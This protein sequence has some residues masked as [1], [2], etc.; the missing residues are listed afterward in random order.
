MTRRTLG[1]LENVDG[2]FLSSS[3]PNVSSSCPSIF[4]V[5]IEVHTS[6]FSLREPAIRK[7]GATVDWLAY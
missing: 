7:A 4:L 3:M 6:T 1:L 5:K 2:L